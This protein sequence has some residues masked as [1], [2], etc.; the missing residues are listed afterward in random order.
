MNQPAHILLT[1]SALSLIIPQAQ[2]YIL[3]IAIFSIIL[4]LDHI[5]GYIKMLT[6]SKKEKSKLKLEDYVSWFR[7]PIQEPIGVLTIEL[8]LLVLYISGIR[9]IILEIAALSIAIHW[10]IDF[11]MVHTRPFAPIDNRIICLFFQ[12][13]K[14][15][16]LSEA[17]ITSASLVLFII[18]YF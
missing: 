7:T 11:L 2:Q 3:P 10:F 8:I 4:D 13:K 9:S 18:A 14:Q 12:T 5:P 1:Y 6:I 15:R 17:I 16:I